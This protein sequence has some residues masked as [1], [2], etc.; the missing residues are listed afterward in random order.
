M[1]LSASA[2]MAEQNLKNVK[3]QER[4]TLNLPPVRIASPDDPD[5]KAAAELAA[6]DI[7]RSEK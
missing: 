3:H 4:A 6:E 1:E 7:I 2:Y 5:I